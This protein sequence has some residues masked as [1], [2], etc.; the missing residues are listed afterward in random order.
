V[1]LFLFKL[2]RFL[3]IAGETEGEGGGQEEK[4]TLFILVLLICT[5]DRIGTHTFF[6]I[7]LLEKK[8]FI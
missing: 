3:F 1:E 2:G 5:H 8:S 4:K 6:C 7:Q